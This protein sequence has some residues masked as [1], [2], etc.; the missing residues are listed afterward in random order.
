MSGCGGGNSDSGG[1]SGGGEPQSATENDLNPVDRDELTPGG[2]L[3]W[4]LSELPPNFNYHQ[5]DGT[6]ADN[7]DVIEALMPAAY[8]FAA[9]ASPTVNEDYFTS[10]E[11]TSED[12]QTIT[13]TINP[14]ATWSDGTPITVADMAAQWQALNG[15]NT[16]YNVSS[17]TGYEEIASV[18]QGEDEKQAVV[19]FAQPYAD[20]Q[21]LF[22]PLYPASTN[23]DPNV[24]NTGW[25]EQPQVTAG[26]FQLE[27]IDRTA[28][29]ITLEPN[30]DWWGDAPLLDRIIYRVISIDAQADALANG[31]IDFVDISSDVNTYQRA[32]ST[33]GVEI[34]RAGG[35]NFRHLTINGTSPV[36]SDVNVRQA[37][38]KAIDRQAIADALLGPLGG[39]AQKLD[40]HIFMSNQEGYQSNAGDLES[41][42]VEGANAQ[43]D[44]AGWTREGD[45]TRTKDGQELVVRMVIPSGVASSAQESQLIQGMLE[46]VGARVEIETVPSG[47][48]FEQYVNTGDF[49]FT[50]F[51]W[52]GTQFPIS[53]TSSIYEQPQGEDIQQNYARIGSQEIDDLYTQV[54]QELD[55]E[56]ARETANEID[57]L[58]WEEVH[59]LTLYQRP[60]LIGANEKLANFGAFGFASVKY[61]D[62][63]FTE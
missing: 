2:D 39:N 5:L 21:A 30:P 11:L 36:L 18:E 61:Q 37:L 57:A 19:T 15:S 7:A 38:A 17:T 8:D 53:S 45:A 44:E 31:E 32:S 10:I 25:T 6:L 63:G 42:D 41:V 49:D 59:S 48:F 24:F 9:D 28:Q 50:V 26:P 62:I 20:W 13:Y 55:P 33:P 3:R 35:P 60:D 40:N 29:T 16:E 47:D 51:A 27:G 56:A 52:L 54:N 46:Q 4:A 58:I 1:G 23:S 22:S 14:D 34:R 43:L 12:P